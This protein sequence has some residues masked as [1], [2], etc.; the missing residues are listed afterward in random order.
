MK[1]TAFARV[2][3]AGLA[4]TVAAVLGGC[5]SDEA[6]RDEESGAITTSGEVEATALEVGDCLNDVAEGEFTDVSA[7]PCA[8]PHDDEIYHSFELEGDEWPGEDAVMAAGDEGC[9]PEFETFAGIAYEDSVLDF[10]S[11]TPVES[12]WN[13]FDDREIQCLIYDTEGQVEG[14]LAGAAR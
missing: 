4:L 3:T 9:G 10:Y 12:S 5:G 6:E 13:D 7:V 2:A 11:I 8:E 1:K 14:S